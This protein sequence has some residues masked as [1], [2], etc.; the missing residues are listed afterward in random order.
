MYTARVSQTDPHA[1]ASLSEAVRDPRY[2]EMNLYLHVEPGHY[3][4][5]SVVFVR[6]KVVVV[7][8]QGPGTVEI[9][10][11]GE[12]G[13]NNVFVVRDGNLELYGVLVRSEAERHAPVHVGQGSRFKAFDCVFVTKLEIELYGFSPEVA[14]CRF[15]GG[16]IDWR[17]Y[18]GRLRDAYFKDA[19]LRFEGAADPVVNSVEFTGGDRCS[20]FVYQSNPTIT[21]CVVT[22][23]GTGTRPAVFVR[24]GSSVRFTNLSVSGDRGY[25]VRVEDAGT[26][27]EFTGLRV[28][29]GS[30]DGCSVAV[31][32]GAVGTF[33]DCRI[34][35]ASVCALWVNG[36]SVT[37]TGLVV[38]DSEAQGLIIEDGRLTG[39]DL[40]FNRLGGTRV[41][42]TDSQLE[43]S[44]VEF[45]DHSP[46]ADRFVPG[47]YLRGSR[48]EME[49]LRAS[50]MTGPLAGF[51]DSQATLTAVSGDGN[52]GGILVEENSTVRAR[53]LEFSHSDGNVLSVRSAS[54][55]EAED[56]LAHECAYNTVMVQGAG[57]TLRSATL[58]G[59]RGVGVS[60]REGAVLTLE[61]AVVQETDQA[62]VFVGDARSRAK[63]VR[64]RITGN[65]GAGVHAHPDA[66]VELRDVTLRDNGG[67]D[68][69]YLQEEKQAEH[70]E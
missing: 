52:A 17:G 6:N 21:D 62:G 14:N 4:E 61:D 68:R 29:G 28:H 60:V 56:V 3:V 30:D 51:A 9:S 37:V 42:G 20:L 34:T 5:P 43:L 53:G 41:N 1:F 48:L 12:D 22:D 32:E 69:V 49:R 19:S 2:R 31:T 45:R 64:S 67:G 66:V 11:S 38:E 33:T 40:V 63:V 15:E 54:Y 25:P 58:R 8:V 36:G 24:G 39:R 16:G 46:G 59:S 44:D 35:A 47:I 10:T 13:E 57:L 27:A 65:A 55:M 7:P 50:G 26:E 23:G 70:T 18:G